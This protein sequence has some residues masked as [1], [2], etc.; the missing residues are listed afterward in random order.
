MEENFPLA[1]T[2]IET[3]LR[4]QKPDLTLPFN[5]LA[6]MTMAI[7]GTVFPDVRS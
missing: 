6:V 2:L 3:D 7:G 4:M 5:V 1:I